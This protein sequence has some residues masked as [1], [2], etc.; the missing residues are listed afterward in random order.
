MVI[1][2]SPELRM[3]EIVQYDVEDKLKIKIWS[4][5]KAPKLGNHI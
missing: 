3:G 2:L 4:L 5:G 1:Y